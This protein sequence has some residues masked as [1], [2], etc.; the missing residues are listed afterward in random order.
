MEAAKIL[1]ADIL[2]IIFEN[3]NK[4]YGAYDLRNTYHKRVLWSLFITGS[5]CVLFLSAFIFSERFTTK[6]QLYTIRDNGVVI[7][8]YQEKEKEIIIPPKE[9][10]KPTIEP[11][12]QKIAFTNPIVVDDKSV[13]TPPPAQDDFDKS[14]IDVVTTE[15]VDDKNIVSVAPIVDDK[16]ILA[17]P[18]KENE[19]PFIKVEIE[20]SYNGGTTAWK[21]YLERNLRG[22]VPVENG[23]TPGTY[24]VTIQFVV[25]K[26]G[27]LSDIQPITSIGYGMEQE[28]IRVIKKSGKWKPAIQ[29]GKEVKA[30]RKQPITFQVLEQ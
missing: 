15:G 17:L 12:T 28:A 19:E 16:K 29:N 26:E 1:T 8:D 14:R 11:Q 5:I 18:E 27:N 21:N 2:D 3:R 24:T 4:A 6:D 25:D 13:K 9:I 22:E 20:A 7:Q 23:A 10:P 30:Y